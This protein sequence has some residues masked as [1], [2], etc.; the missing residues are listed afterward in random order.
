MTLLNGEERVH[1]KRLFL[2]M[3]IGMWSQKRC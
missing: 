3:Q 2:Q 1:T